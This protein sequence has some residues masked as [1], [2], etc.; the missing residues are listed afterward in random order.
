MH[1]KNNVYG[2]VYGI[3]QV[4]FPTLMDLSKVSDII[5]HQEYALKGYSN[6][7]NSRTK[8]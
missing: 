7:Y 1:K 4:G 6:G 3:D 2:N 8:E 5:Y